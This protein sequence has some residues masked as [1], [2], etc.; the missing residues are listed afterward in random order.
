MIRYQSVDEIPD[1]A[2][3]SAFEHAPSIQFS[4]RAINYL[5]YRYIGIGDLG[6][7][8]P[9][10]RALSVLGITPQMLRPAFNPQVRF[11]HHRRF[12]ALGD[13]FGFNPIM[14]VRVQVELP[15]VI[16]DYS[17]LGSFGLNGPGFG[18][19]AR[20]INKP[21]EVWRQDG[22]SGVHRYLRTHLTTGEMFRDPLYFSSGSKS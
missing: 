1:E 11:R 15:E 9:A 22:G 2:I 19:L 6:L 8:L 4:A 16:S 21:V 3:V 12:P 7:W 18:Q 5:D 10:R 13:F 14:T 20:I 17:E